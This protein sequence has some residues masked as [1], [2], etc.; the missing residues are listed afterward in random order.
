[1]QLAAFFGPDKASKPVDK[2]P[3]IRDKIKLLFEQ[4][5]LGQRP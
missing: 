1:V 4:I 5:N 2:R 3:T